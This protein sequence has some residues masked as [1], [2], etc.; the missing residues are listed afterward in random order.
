M[1]AERA[2]PKVPPGMDSDGAL[3]VQEQIGVLHAVMRNPPANALS[4]PL[5]TALRELVAGFER[6]S[7]KVLVLSSDVPGF[8]AAGADLKHMSSL[9]AQD[10]ADYRDAVRGALEQ[11]AGCG[12]PSIAAIEGRALGGGLELAMACTLR[13]CSRDASF[14]L[15]EV[16]LGLVPA[17][18]GTQRLPRLVGR[19]RALELMLSGRELD[20]EEASRIGLVDRVVDENAVGE[21][22]E[23]ADA[24]ARLSAP[25][26]AAI[27]SCV[28]A[29][30][31]LPHQEGMA[32]EAAA[33]MST[34]E[35]GEAREGITAFVEKRRAVFG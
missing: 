22:L 1:A 12:R 10:L 16:K 6:G 33:M 29:A 2:S 5:V 13:C 21:A 11:L 31:D 35:E 23:L 15:P 27:I 17:G 4:L 24:M 20:A 19:G 32:V 34:F 25:A 3:I 30:R 7:A 28:D 18:G 8:F 9:T 26:M 14:G